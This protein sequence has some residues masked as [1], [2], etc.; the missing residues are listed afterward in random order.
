MAGY[1][2]IVV[3]AEKEVACKSPDHIMPWGTRR[4]NSRNPRFNQ[5]LYRLYPRQDDFLKVLDLGCSGGGFVRDCLNDGCLAVGL[6]GSDFSKKTRR[7]EWATIPG[8]LFT[9]DITEEFEVL[10]EDEKGIRRIQFDVVTAWEVIEHIAE[11]DLP[12]VAENV[13]KHLQPAGLWIMSV[14]PNEEILSGIRLHQTVQAKPWWVE[15]FRSL[16]LEHIEEYVQYF[17]T[18]Y[19]RGPKYG[20]P[21]SFHLILSPDPSMSPPIPKQR[22]TEVLYDMWLGSKP[23]LRIRRWL[24]GYQLI[25]L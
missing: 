4:D 10:Q 6:E 23:Q 1:S 17:N 3:R 11:D 9:C 22:L 16:G 20:A 7:A 21:G 12:R 18:Q 14:S 8:Y 19:V 2:R 15:K 5:K 24:V 13:I 25:L